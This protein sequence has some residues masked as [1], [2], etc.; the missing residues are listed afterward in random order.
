MS[1][2][3]YDRLLRYSGKRLH[4]STFVSNESLF[5]YSW[6]HTS[7]VIHILREY[8]EG[9]IS[10][11]NVCKGKLSINRVANANSRISLITLLGEWI[12]TLTDQR[13]LNATRIKYHER[14]M[15]RVIS[16]T[17]EQWYGHWLRSWEI[18]ICDI[19]SH[20]DNEH[21]STCSIHVLRAFEHGK[22]LFPW[23]YN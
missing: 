4:A 6:R 20:Y 18:L 19:Q 17:I 16:N 8:H 13:A 15:K 10:Q 3:A 14:T 2:V 9:K 12:F 22:I 21:C 11:I 5:Y 7:E 23:K 1:I